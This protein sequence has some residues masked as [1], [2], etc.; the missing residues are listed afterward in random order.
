MN[1]QLSQIKWIR[2]I[3][4]TIIII[5]IAFL[6]VTLIITGYASYL[7][8]QA[9]GAPD[10]NMINTFAEQYAPLLNSVFLILFTFFGARHAARRVEGAEQINALA[11]GV[12]S[13]LVHAGS[14]FANLFDINALPVSILAI[15]AGWLGGKIN[16]KN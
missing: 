10:V 3:L 16:A 1:N 12:L 14:N 5:I 9:R 4:T 13:G 11:V 6:A 8:F 15:G 7:G 2:V